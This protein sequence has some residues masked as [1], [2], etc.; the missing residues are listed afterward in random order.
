ALLIY[1]G[2]QFPRTHN[3]NVLIQHI[4]DSIQIPEEVF[5]A[6][7]LTDYAVSSRY[8]GIVNLLP[9]L[10]TKWLSNQPSSF[11]NGFLIRL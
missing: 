8:P 11:S 9:N 1:C 7:K 5:E 4:P 10:N 6:A 3:I 2:I